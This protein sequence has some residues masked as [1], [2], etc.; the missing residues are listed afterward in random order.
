MAESIV[1]AVSRSPDERR[2][3]EA[4]EFPGRHAVYISR[5][6]I[7]DYEGRYEFWDADTEIA[8]VCE[9]TSYYHERPLH[10]LAKL[11]D[12]IAAVRGAPI[13]AVGRTDL[14]LLNLRG[15]RQRIMQAD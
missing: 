15:E 14:L 2:A 10:R 13:G 6:N 9:P 11:T 12:R 8:M 1:S 5:D 4:L 3:P 7:A